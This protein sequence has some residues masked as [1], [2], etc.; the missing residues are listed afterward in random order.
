M[1]TGRGKKETNKS[2]GFSRRSIEAIFLPPLLKSE[3]EV[4]GVA[5]AVGENLKP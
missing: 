3:A 5:P 2:M 1:D 4:I